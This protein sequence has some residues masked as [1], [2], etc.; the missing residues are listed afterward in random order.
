MLE[1]PYGDIRVSKP[2]DIEAL[3]SYGAEPILLACTNDNVWRPVGYGIE[4]ASAAWN[5]K[6]FLEDVAAFLIKN[7][8]HD[9]LLLASRNVQDD[10]KNGYQY[11]ETNYGATRTS[12]VKLVEDKYLE[13]AVKT[14]FGYTRGPNG[15][16]ELY[17]NNWCGC[18]DC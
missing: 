2:V 14:T 7:N 9:K 18:K 16:V 3:S 13:D 6:G 4:K 11:L 10:K 17:C 5:D 12:E 15:E 1:T 8:L